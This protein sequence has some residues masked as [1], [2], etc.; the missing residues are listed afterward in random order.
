MEGEA[1]Q[2]PGAKMV[3]YFDPYKNPLGRVATWVCIPDVPVHCYNRHCLT[4][5][6]NRIG[7]ILKVDMHT[8]ANWLAPDSKVERAK[9]VRICVKLDLQKKLVPRILAAGSVFNIEYE[10]HRTICFSCG[11]VGHGREAC[12]SKARASCDADSQTPQ[13]S[14]PPPAREQVRPPPPHGR[15]AG[16]EGRFG[17]WMINQKTKKVKG[18]TRTE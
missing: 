17:P 2:R 7:K 8:L 1:A 11:K 13:S 18:S 12:P 3:P 14:E 6:G 16:E 15:A 4:R 5:I 9:F 10:G